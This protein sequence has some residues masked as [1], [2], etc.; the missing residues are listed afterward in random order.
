MI[1]FRLLT[2]SKVDVINMGTFL[3]KRAGYQMSHPIIK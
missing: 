2:L 1:K 3:C